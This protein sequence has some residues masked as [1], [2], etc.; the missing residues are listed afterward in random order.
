MNN[1]RRIQRHLVKA[2]AAGAL[3]AAAALPMAIASVAGAAGLPAVTAVSI[4]PHG[5]TASSVGAGATGTVAI[6]GTNFINDGG[7]ASLAAVCTPNSDTYTFTSVVETSTTTATASFTSAGTA[8][9]TCTL[10]IT[11]DGGAQATPTATAITVDAAPTI[12]TLSPARIWDGT[13]PTTVTIPGTGFATGATVSLTATSN[14]TPLTAS[15]TSV[16]ATAIVLSVTPTN[17][18]NGQPAA[19]GTYAVTVTNTDGGAATSATGFYVGNGL[20]NVSP[21]ATSAAASVPVT[22][23]GSGFEY[24]ATVSLTSTDNAACFTE[25][26]NTATETVNGVTVTNAL[27]TSAITSPT[28][29]TAT[30]V[31]TSVA[32]PEACGLTVTNGTGAGNNT[33]VFNL[34]GAFGVGIASTVAPV[35]TSVSPTTALTVGAA[36]VT[37]TLTGS[38]FSSYSILGAD[39][40][41][42]LYTAGNGAGGTTFTFNAAATTGVTAGPFAVIVTTAAGNPTSYTPAITV[43][44]PSIASQAPSL[45]V[46][47]PIGTTVVLTGTGF[48]NTTSGTASGT[49]TGTVSYASATTLNLVVTGS[50]TST[51]GGVVNVSTVTG[52]GTV[53]SPT[54]TLTINAA[55][56]V[57]SA[58]TYATGAGT[59]VGVGA[60]A[61][62][63]YIHGLGF[64]TGATV[65]T[66]V[67]GAAVADPNV[68]A[69]VT[70][71]TATQITATVA[72][73]GPDTNTSVG[74]TVTNPDGGAAKVA[75]F[76]YPIF[77]GAGPTITSVTPAAGKAGTTTSFAVAGTGFE[78][79]AVVT[80][81]PANGTCTAP[82]ITATTTLAATCTLG[83]PSS[84]AT[85]LVV[86]NPDGGSATSTTAVLPANTVK[87]VAFHVS[88]VHGAAVAGKTVTITISGTGFYGQP[89]ITSTAVGS[90]FAVA[91][92]NGRLLT[93]H[94]TIKA[95]TKAGEHTLTVRL[96][97]GKTGKAGF[98]IKA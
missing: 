34:A 85:D 45:V 46:G 88:G 70:A 76:A 6:T 42:V 63:V 95:G 10:A 89:K 90:K 2:L 73:K 12:G 74:Y 91:K 75:A 86:T 29:G 23:L 3:L 27:A 25:I 58:V 28:A 66:F 20:E 9:A 31:V 40:T 38:G 32:T 39:P 62:T 22:L 48:T 57:N 60:T 16:S 68:T 47:A 80:L 55:P 41:D 33:A 50:P 51:T 79:G 4:T 77:I 84:V 69:T 98:N 61:Q 8:A 21:S 92:D 13:G 19:S 26:T 49:L 56:T 37:E 1:P 78:T 97:N 64:E 18:V 96:A 54:F 82:T 81:S 53:A 59:D 71:V 24:G 43:A 14:S 65:A 72:I 35:V 5:A 7:A 93:V 87:V 11:D 94:A 15:V 67:N 30:I 44:G 83:Q 52:T 36:A 17:S